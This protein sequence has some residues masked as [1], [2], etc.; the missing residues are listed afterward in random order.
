MRKRSGVAVPP[1]SLQS[2]LTKLKADINTSC[3]SDTQRN[4][5]GETKQNTQNK[6]AFRTSELNSVL[7]TDPWQNSIYLLHAQT[8][9]WEFHFMGSFEYVTSGWRTLMSQRGR[10]KEVEGGGQ[11]GFFLK[12][13]Y[14]WFCFL[15]L[16]FSIKEKKSIV[17]PRAQRLQG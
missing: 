4:A 15:F 14:I 2:V 7:K 17:S 12:M 5:C 6:A 3:G 1:Y 8:S 10:E 11:K 13:L 16:F 9:L